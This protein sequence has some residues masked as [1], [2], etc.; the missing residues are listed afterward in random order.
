MIKICGSAIIVITHPLRSLTQ[1]HMWKQSMY[2][3]QDLSVHTVKLFVP[4]ERPCQHM[5]AENTNKCQIFWWLTFEVWNKKSIFVIFVKI[6]CLLSDLDD[7]I[8]SKMQKTHEGMWQCLFCFR[9]S[10]VKTN[11]FEHI[12][13]NHVETPGYSCDV[14]S[15]PCRTRNALRAHKHREHN[16]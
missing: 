12:E 2:K 5:L 4:A 16:T 6:F 11:I 14:C 10:K 13:A 15:K 3:I 9:V 1:N 8:R 7:F